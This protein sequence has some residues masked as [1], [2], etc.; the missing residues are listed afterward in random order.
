M[1]MERKKERNCKTITKRRATGVSLTSDNVMTTNR[2][3]RKKRMKSTMRT[4]A[5]RR[6]DA[7][8]EGKSN[9]RNEDSLWQAKMGMR[10][11]RKMKNRGR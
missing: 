11:E 7:E 4:S 5:T 3:T 10:N 6:T 1:I 2:T 8:R 9:Q